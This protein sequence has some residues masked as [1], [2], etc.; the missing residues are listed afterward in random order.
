M[1]TAA[2]RYYSTF[3]IAAA[4]AAL[5]QYSRTLFKKDMSTKEGIKHPAKILPW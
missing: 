2:L 5:R 4:G 3:G 1:N